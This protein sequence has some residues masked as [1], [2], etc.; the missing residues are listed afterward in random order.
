MGLG[1][2]WRAIGVVGV[3]ER[4]VDGRGSRQHVSG[5]TEWGQVTHVGHVAGEAGRAA[6]R[7]GLVLHA[8]G[9]LIEAVPC[10]LVPLGLA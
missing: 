2:H 9:Q 10:S 5:V 1:P 7:G 6:K 8:L 3:T 4:R